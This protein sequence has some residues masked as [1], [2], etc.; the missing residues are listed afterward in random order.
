MNKDQYA[1]WIRQRNIDKDFERNGCLGPEPED[2][3]EPA[4][5]E[6]AS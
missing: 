5:E 4:E 1:D 6:D 3:P 2:E